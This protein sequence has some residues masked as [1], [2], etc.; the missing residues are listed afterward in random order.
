M[1]FIFLFFFA[2]VSIS[3]ASDNPYADEFNSE[4][5]SKLE[6]I[7]IK[8]EYQQKIKSSSDFIRLLENLSNVLNIL[9]N[10][11]SNN[12]KLN[13]FVL[14]LNYEIDRLLLE[15]ENSDINTSDEDNTTNLENTSNTENT[16][17][18]DNNSNTTSWMDLD[19]NC[20]SQD[21]VV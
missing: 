18:E 6:D 1:I 10:Y 14:Y 4:T 3:L 17:D 16:S 19:S 2:F 8:L 7:I 13:N 20:N 12:I 21:I 5:N 15:V 9:L 11:Y